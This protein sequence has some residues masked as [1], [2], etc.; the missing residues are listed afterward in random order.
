MRV[1]HTW[2]TSSTQATQYASAS[3]LQESWP[4]LG[5]ASIWSSVH[6]S[7]AASDRL[8]GAPPSNPCFARA[9]GGATVGTAA[10]PPAV[11]VVG[12][13]DTF[14]PCCFASRIS[15]I[16]SANGSIPFGAG[17]PNCACHAAELGR[18]AAA[19]PRADV[20]RRGEVSLCNGF[21]RGEGVALAV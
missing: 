10:A 4:S 16:R 11:A 12:R 3:V 15:Q 8:E 17:T 5:F 18:T 2:R 9:A 6:D 13:F 14:G 19:C 7:S 21:E 20:V 1:L